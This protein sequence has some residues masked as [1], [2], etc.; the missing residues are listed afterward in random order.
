M[1]NIWFKRRNK[2][3]I[4]RDRYSEYLNRGRSVNKLALQVWPDLRSLL[5]HNISICR[6]WMPSIWYLSIKKKTGQ[7]W[8]LF[9]AFRER[10][11]WSFVFW[12]KKDTLLYD[13]KYLA[14]SRLPGILECL[15][16]YIS[17]LNVLNKSIYRSLP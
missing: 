6:L 2:F 13:R 12:W 9:E 10:A 4:D 15:F 16:Q 8:R 1:Q 3:L 5:P 17:Y 11:E 7:K 14:E